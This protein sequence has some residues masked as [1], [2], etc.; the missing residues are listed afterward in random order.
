MDKKIYYIYTNLPSYRNDFFKKLSEKLGEDNIKLEVLYGTKID[1][2]VIPQIDKSSFCKKIFLSKFHRLLF[3]NF[4]KM[5]G[6]LNYIKKSPPQACVISYVSTNLS[7][8]NVVLYCLRHKIPYATWRCGYNRPDYSSLQEKIRNAI[9]TFV[10]K[11]AAYNITYGSFYQQELIKKGISEKKVIIAQNT[12][13][14]ESII[15]ENRNYDKKFTDKT[16]VLFVGALIKGKLLYSSIDA[17]KKIIEEGY[18]ISFTIVGGG[19]MLDELQRYVTSLQLQDKIKIV[20]PKFKDEV[21]ECFRTSDVF[22]LAG[23]GGLAINEAM[24]YGLP[25]ISTNADGTACDLIKGN[26]YYMDAFG[27]THLQYKYLKSFMHLSQEEKQKMSEKSKQ[28]I[29]QKASL[30]NM[31][32]KHVEAC[33]NLINKNKI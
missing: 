15:E 21:K 31:V 29:Q 33:L 12:I 4:V 26:G 3:F 6:L 27:D 23:T 32:Y 20:G 1:N 18:A 13:N 7:M 2:K 24:A 14:I 17:V 5:G 10:E 28:I 25:I 9:I 8:L 19:E 30:E 11:K 16:R 22:L